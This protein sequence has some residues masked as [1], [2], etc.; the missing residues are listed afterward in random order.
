MPS[1]RFARPLILALA[2]VAALVTLFHSHHSSTHSDPASKLTLVLAAYETDGLR[3]QWLKRILDTYASAQYADLVAGIVLVWNRPGVDPPDGLPKSVKVVRAPVNSLNNRWTLTRG[4]VKTPGMVVTDNDLVLSK[5]ALKCLHRVWQSHPTR[6]IG[7]FVRRR[8]GSS[9]VLDELVARP[10]PYNFVLPRALVG[11]TE[12]VGRYAEK[13][14]E[15]ERRYVDEQEAHCDDILLN[16]VVGQ[17]TRKAPLR[18]ALPPG[19]IGDFATYCS[20]LNR[21]ASS[22]LA[23]QSSRAAL[24]TECLEHFMDPHRGGVGGEKRGFGPEASPQGSLVA[25][26]SDDGE[27]FKLST[28][29]IGLRRWRAMSN[30]TASD[31]CPDLAATVPLAPPPHALTPSRSAVGEE[32]AEY[33][34]EVTKAVSEWIDVL[35]SEAPLCGA[36][37]EREREVEAVRENARYQCGAWCIWDL[38]LSTKSGWRLRPSSSV[39][40]RMCF[41]RFENGHRD[42]DE[43]W[44]QRPRFDL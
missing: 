28:S 31:L 1:L 20:P 34:P 16:L 42:C 6:L 7:P 41:E 10:S 14:W 26:C 4:L 29:D 27:T 3:P 15:E 35:E 44:Y 30:L 22:G 8:D 37:G 36:Q 11:S 40:G 13:E 39:R 18:V 19:S 9:Y 5:P 2:L 12:L 25:V 21:P 33:C 43:W 23:D 32:L 17:T 38:R 24:R